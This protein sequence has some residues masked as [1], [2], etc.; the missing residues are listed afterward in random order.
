MRVCAATVLA[1]ALIVS[2]AVP[3]CAASL[4]ASP[5]TVE[6][7]TPASTSTVTLRNEGTSPLNAQIR[8]FR[9]TQVDGEEKL[10][11]SE[12]VVASPPVVLLQAKADY[13]LRIVRVT[14]QAVS[15]EEAEPFL[16]EDREASDEEEQQDRGER[17]DC[18]RGQ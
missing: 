1:S 11:T 8:V 2:A 7:Q 17:S 14:K 13:T 10:V 16:R 4:Q 18:E 12:D 15:G 9:W 3:A 6:I 5:V